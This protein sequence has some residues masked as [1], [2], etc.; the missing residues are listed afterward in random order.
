MEKRQQQ[1]SISYFLVTL[2]LILLF[3]NFFM[4]H[5]IQT[6]EYSEFKALL[7][8]GNVARV[9]LGEEYLQGALR[10]AGLEGILPKDK[11]DSIVKTTGKRDA[12][13]L[14]PFATVRIN[15]PDLVRELEAAGV[16]YTEKLES[17]WFTTL[18]S[19]VIPALIFFGLWSV[20]IRRM[21]PQQGLMSIGKSKAK[22]FMEKSTGATFKDIAGIDEAKAESTPWAKPV[23]QI[24]W[25]P[26]MSASKP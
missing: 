9:T 26:R 14:D 18:L 20:L 7:R 1:F 16:P 11:I 13:G 4:S 19:W 3:Q 6:L 12:S 5:H 25:A 21:G 23:P 8:A 2:F 17:T 22:V 15:D 10:T 24:L